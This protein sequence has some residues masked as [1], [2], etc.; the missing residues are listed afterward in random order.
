MT[1]I[2]LFALAAGDHQDKSVL[3][4]SSVAHIFCAH[5]T[6]ASFY[7][8]IFIFPLSSFPHLKKS[9]NLFEISEVNKAEQ[10]ENRE[11]VVEGRTKRK[12]VVG[13]AGTNYIL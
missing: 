4:P 12:G 5:Y 1:G 6:R 2:S 13:R 3:T 11:N 8:L 9:S 7:H 10:K